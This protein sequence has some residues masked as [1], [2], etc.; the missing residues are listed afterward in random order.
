MVQPANG[1]SSAS[2]SNAWINRAAAHIVSFT[3]R[4][5]CLVACSTRTTRITMKRDLPPA[6]DASAASDAPA[7]ARAAGLRY[8]HDYLPGIARKSRGKHFRYI[9][10]AGN[11]VSDA[12]TLA[13]IRSLAIPP[14]WT[15]VWICQHA[16]GHL[17]ATGR[18]AKGRKQ[19]RYHPRWRA[20]RDESKYGRM[21]SFGKALPAIRAA[22]D[23]ALKL[24]G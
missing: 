13:R 20:L 1:A 11:V 23:T 3:A 4:V 22:V 24:P 15:D 18:D 14:A 19:Y 9:G 12:D 21:L 16:N 17:Q 7:T 5:R 2:A 8:A 10:A 6:A